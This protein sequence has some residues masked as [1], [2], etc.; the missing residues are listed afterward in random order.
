[1]YLPIIGLRSFDF[2]SKAAQKFL[3]TILIT[4]RL[5]NELPALAVIA[6]TYTG[7]ASA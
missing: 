7:A 4:G 1:M 5:G 6:D 3:T 2:R